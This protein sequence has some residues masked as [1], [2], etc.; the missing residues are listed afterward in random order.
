MALYATLVLIYIIFIYFSDD[1]CTN[2]HKTG[3]ASSNA[4]FML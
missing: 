2:D 4:S 1:V 3:N